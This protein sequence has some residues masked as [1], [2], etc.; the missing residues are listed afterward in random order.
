MIFFSFL[1]FFKTGKK[2]VY[3]IE[4]VN[5]KSEM[6]T[7]SDPILI[8]G[9]KGKSLICMRQNKTKTPKYSGD[10]SSLLAKFARKCYRVTSNAKDGTLEFCFETES[11]L[12]GISLG[13][14]SGY[15]FENNVLR[16]YTEGGYK[17]KNR[18]YSLVTTYECD[19]TVSGKNPNFP[20]FWKKNECE[21]QTIVKTSKLCRHAAFSNEHVINVKCIERSVYEG[22]EL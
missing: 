4:M 18:K 14:F 2:P 11:F 3:N 17:C 5:L 13:W 8:P 21:I 12:N 7:N 9:V 19:N 10:P 1:F 20:I 16:S 15:K 22:I 6:P